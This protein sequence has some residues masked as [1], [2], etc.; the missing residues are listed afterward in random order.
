MEHEI[1]EIIESALALAGYKVLDGD[2]D[3]VIVRHA[4]GDTDYEIKVSEIY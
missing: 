2:N 3:T 4:T 1:F